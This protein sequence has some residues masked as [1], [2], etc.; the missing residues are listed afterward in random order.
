[1]LPAACLVPR[2]RRRGQRSLHRGQPH[3]HHGLPRLQRW[4]PQLPQLGHLQ[5]QETLQA[6]MEA[7]A[8]PSLTA[9]TWSGL[10]LGLG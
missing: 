5:R 9:Q 6:D 2:A 7:L 1:M 4:Q 10:E 8:A 3:L